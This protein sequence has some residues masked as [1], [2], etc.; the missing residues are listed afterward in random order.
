MSKRIKKKDIE[1]EIEKG[2]IEVI[3]A[4][5][6]IKGIMN[7]VFLAGS[8]EMGKAIDWQTQIIEKCIDVDVTLFNPRRED[9]DSSWEQTI[10]N[11]DFKE[12]VEWEM[13]SMEQANKIV[14]YMDENTKSPITLLELGLHARDRKSCVYCPDKFWRKGNVEIVCDRYNI[15][16]VDDMEGLIKFIKNE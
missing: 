14:F 2:K 4:P 15:P 8:I 16:M 3:Y 10:D 1:S 9:W 12:Q 13:D 11:P 5:E 7:G 6:S